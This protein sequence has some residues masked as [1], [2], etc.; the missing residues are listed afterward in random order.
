MRGLDPRMLESLLHSHYHCW[1]AFGGRGACAPWYCNR[2]G[3]YG[4]GVRRDE[5]VKLPGGRL[6]DDVPHINNSGCLIA[7]WLTS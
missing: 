6:G 4:R 7:Y 2:P 1:A 5:V 3:T